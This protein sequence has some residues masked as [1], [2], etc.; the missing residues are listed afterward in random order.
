MG[1]IVPECEGYDAWGNDNL[2]AAVSVLRQETYQPDVAWYG[3]DI[4]TFHDT[5]NLY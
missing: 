5:T 1:Q 2:C 3:G 4:E